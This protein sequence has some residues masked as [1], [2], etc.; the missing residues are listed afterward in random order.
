M[1]IMKKVLSML[2]MTTM[3]V[4]ININAF[5]SNKVTDA[6]QV[7]TFNSYTGQQLETVKQLHCTQHQIEFQY[8]EKDFSF[9]IKPITMNT[10]DRKNIKG[11][12]YYYGKSGNLI[13]NLVEYG[14]NYCIQVFDDSKSIWG[15]QNDPNNNFT[16]VS[17][18]QVATNSH[19]IS[20]TIAL[21]NKKMSRDMTR[22]SL[23]VYASGVT[24]PYLLSAGSAEGWCTTTP[25]ENNNYQV[26]SLSYDV[27]YN[28]PSDGVSLWYD[29]QNSIEAYHSPAW[30]S[31]QYTTV[32][33]S[34]TI[35]SGSGAFVAEATVSALVKGTPIMW[36]VYDVS[37]MDGT[38]E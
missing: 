17:G 25:R 20:S 38:H 31:A 30:P 2:F 16:I 10:N 3:F 26:S 33:G 13:C 23:Y 27:T 35:N 9:F 22:G 32:T 15:R 12:N 11:A 29:Y 28:W 18:N 21:Q 5:A 7:V 6:D 14:D 37:F 24:I 8:K 4:T 19:T 34:W 1:K 36:T